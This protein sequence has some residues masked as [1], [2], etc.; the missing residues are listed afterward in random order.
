MSFIP[1]E[2]IK[3]KKSGG[4]H[5]REEVAWI[6]RSFTNG[7][8]KDYQMAAWAMAVW[9]NGMNDDETAAL[10]EAMFRSGDHFD[11]SHLPAARVDKHST[12]GVGD[13]T[14]LLIGPIL[15]AAEVYTPMISGRGLGHTGGTLDKYESIPGFRVNL[16]RKEFESYVTDHYFSVMGQ[17]KDICPADKKLYALRDVTSTVDSLPLICASIMS[18]KLAESL[19]GLV[20]DVKYGSGALMKTISEARKLA[21]LLKSTG[22][23]NGI[24]VTALITNMNEPLGR[25]IGNAVEVQEC[26]EILQGRSHIVNGYDFYQPTR[27][28]SVELSA[29]AILLAKKSSDIVHARNLATELLVSGAALRSFEKL[30]EYQGPAEIQKLPVAQFSAEIKARRSGFVT[31]MQTE[32]IGLAG[33]ELGCGRKSA[34]D[35]VDHSA[36]IEMCVHLGEKIKSGQ[37]LCRYFSNSQNSLVFAE[38][39]LSQAIEIGETDCPRQSLVADT[40]ADSRLSR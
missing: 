40:L 28:L 3:K 8:F 10:T 23:K 6:V 13:K 24:R 1:A 32:Q 7:D 11:F 19:T 39:M 4:H 25:F 21:L 17:T 31:N 29:H 38:A 20:L 30:L 9:F 27:D 34:T 26:Y 12:G 2:L 15:A 22:E 18:K 16:S 5:S 37:T 14:S 33:I 36:G 35:Q